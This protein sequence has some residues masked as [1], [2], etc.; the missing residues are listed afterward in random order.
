MK[1]NHPV[2]LIYKEE[3]FAI[4]GASFE[5]SNEKGCGFTEAIYQECLE[6]ELGLR[7][8]AFEAQA[9]LPLSYK[10]RPLRQRFQPDFVCM[11]KIIVEIKAVSS[12]ADEHRSQVLNYLNATGFRLGLLV[13]FG[14]PRGLEWERIVR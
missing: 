14:H 11:G 5:V 6:I 13:N 9:H 1:S 4:I 2:E 3:C 12:L 10:E 8:I 7:G